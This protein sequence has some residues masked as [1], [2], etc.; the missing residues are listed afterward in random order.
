[1]KLK[2]I[3]II[4][5]VALIIVF[6]MA[7]T[8]CLVSK[9]NIANAYTGT[10][11]EG[12]PYV[13]TT[14]SELRDL[15][16][17]APTNG[18]TRYISLGSNIVSNDSNNDYC[19]TLTD[20]DQK[21]VLDLAGHTITR[22]PGVSVDFSV[23]RAKEGTLTINDSVGA[24]GIYA[25]DTIYAP[26]GLIADG[27]YNDNGTIIIN[28]GTYVANKASGLSYGIY[29][30]RGDV[31]ITGGSF[32]GKYGVKI[33]AGS[34]NIYGGEFNATEYEDIYITEGSSTNLY[35]L[36]AHSKIA[37]SNGN[38][39]DYIPSKNVT[40]NGAKKT[41]TST[42]SILGT[43]IDII[44]DVVD[45]INI[46][47]SAPSVGNDM[48]TSAVVLGEGYTIYEE[49]GHQVLSWFVG[50]ALVDGQFATGT[51]Y[52][53]KMY[54]RVT[55]VVKPG[56]IA[57]INQNIAVLEFQSESNGENYY[58]VSYT[59]PETLNSSLNLNLDESGVLSWNSIGGATG[60]RVF[61][62]QYG[63]EVAYWD[64]TNTFI[65]IKTEMDGIKLNSGSYTLL[66][67]A[68]GVSASASKP[69]YYTSNV[70]RYEAPQNVQWIGNYA[71][72]EYVEGATAYKLTL[73]GF[74]GKV[75]S[76]N[77]T[78]SPYD[79]SVYSPQN[80]WT[81]TVQTLGNGTLSDKRD[82]AIVESPAKEIRTKTLPT[83]NSNNSLNMRVSSDGILSWDS[84]TNATGYQVVLRQNAMQVTHWDTTNTILNLVTEL[85]GIKL[86]SGSYIVE[87]GA[88]GVSK[89]ASMSYFYTSNVDQLEVPQNLQWIGIHAAWDS[90]EGA[91]A[92]KLTLYG[93]NGQVFTINTEN[94]LY[95][96]SAYSL[97][98]GWTFTVQ[99]L[100]NGTVSGKRDSVIAE[101]P[102]LELPKA[103]CYIETCAYN[104]VAQQI[105]G[106]IVSITTDKGTVVSD[107][108]NLYPNIYA[109]EGTTVTLQANAAS[110]FKFVGWKKDS[111]FVI[112]SLST[113]TTYNFTAT[114]DIFVYGSFQ[115]VST[116]SFDANGGSGTMADDEEQ[117]GG[118]V[119]PDSTFTAPA[120]KQLKA[121]AVGS[122][123]G[124]QYV[125]GSEY[126]VTSD[127]TFY[128]I[129][130][131]LAFTMQP[132]SQAK[133]CDGLDTDIT[134]KWDINFTATKYVVME[135]SSEFLTIDTPATKQFTR[136]YDVAT[137]KNLIVRA[138]YDSTNY[139][140]SDSFT[141][142]W[143]NS[144]V[145]VVYTPGD[146]DGSN[147]TIEY[148][149]NSTISLLDLKY[150]NFTKDGCVFDCWSI[151]IMPN[152]FDEVAQKNPGETYA[153]T[154]SNIIAVATW[155]EKE[156]DHLEATYSESIVAGNVLDT[157]KMTIKLFYNDG[158]YDTKDKNQASFKIGTTDLTID[159]YVFNTTG[160]IE[161]TVTSEEKSTT[162]IV[163]V[164]GYQ[165]VFNANGG[166]GSMVGAKDQYGSYALPTSTFT[167]PEGKQFLKWAEGSASGTQYNAGANYN[168]TN[169]ITFYA[170]W[171][172][173]QPQSVSATYTGNVLGGKSL[174]VK[175]IGVTLTFTDSTTTDLGLLDV[176][177]WEDST[178]QIQSI[179]SYKFTQVGEVSI[180]V[181]YNELQT[182][183]SVNVVGYTVSFNANTGS[184][185][186][187]AQQNKYGNYILP[188]S[189][190]TA[191]TGKQFKGWAYTSDGETL[192][193]SINVTTNTELFAIWEDKPAVTHQI[194]FNANG[195]SGTMNPDNYAGTYTLPTCTFTAPSGKQ[196]NGWALSADGNIISTP[197][198]IV[199]EDI[200]LFAIW[201]DGEVTPDSGDSGNKGGN[202]DGANSIDD[203]AKKP[204]GGGAIAGIVIAVV[205]VL[206]AAGFCVYWFIFRK[207]KVVSP[208]VEENKEEQ[209][210]ETP[211]EEDKT[212]E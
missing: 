161:V 22:N 163:N 74:E 154:T 150:F 43:N 32:K 212:E 5:I 118:Y 104:L 106:G 141:L 185:S 110:G 155:V 204:L 194:S 47:I 122:A 30:Q 91:S 6:V 121:W 207:K 147:E 192:D 97:Q 190:L 129:W 87:V 40:V 199:T 200:E 95:N 114:E 2:R 202:Q 140:E 179:A 96:L 206:G 112:A 16:A 65:A 153:L 135:G 177:Y 25:G 205:V 117:Y 82:S 59:F 14:Y 46:S 208:K 183:M 64:V 83:V 164:T 116:V 67:G 49:Y 92:Y 98:D 175:N 186:M 166:T 173:K 28:G 54:V 142:T 52:K 156:R 171:S 37:C 18:T 174:D 99:A 108:E 44:S 120:G 8:I 86:N 123:S 101:S 152:N 69:Y 93:F 1:M 144:T 70:G 170:L 76:I 50:D 162:M 184:G 85:D 90:V 80:G 138:Y 75:F 45:E 109:T 113:N 42:S 73:Y 169:N 210:D 127:V 209:P 79:L 72:W 160:N 126:N 36:N 63:M 26:I 136:S 143:A 11:T 133:Y 102:A 111:P 128:A 81:F 51:T 181:K 58:W 24:G 56:L 71:A 17:N 31:V 119:L 103:L 48:P 149:I 15:M 77:T 193:T 20:E 145:Q 132:I 78:T 180:I 124:E 21:V 172:N 105:S 203:K 198:I 27:I 165:V 139:I 89:S 38:I 151:R 107:G 137:V 62:Q 130:E 29:N 35:R 211:V 10:G 33:D 94:C 88:K 197:T 148:N 41:V 66:V 187:A 39:W 191:P 158:S 100:G 182:M 57:K 134:T 68:K 159:S 34:L 189:T 131:D 196:F 55:G 168:V 9:Q 188:A 84:V 53:V 19:L 167:A 61:V 13:I 4:S 3:S 115:K 178:H 195:G 176:T 125:V 12:D 7:L 157:S 60:Y 201:E 23:V 146:G